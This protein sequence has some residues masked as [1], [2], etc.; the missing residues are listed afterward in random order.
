MTYRF[1]LA[2]S[3]WD[4]NELNAI[5][6]VIDSDR[7]TM[8]SHVKEFEKRFAE[9]IG[10]KYAVMVNSGSSAN[11]I[12]VASLFYTKDKE[13]QLKKGDEVIVPS[14]SWSTTYFPL[15]QYGLKIKFVDIDLETLNIDIE[16][17]NEAITERTKAIFCVN[18]LGNSSNYSAIKK[19][20]K[21]KNILILEDN[22]ESLGAEYEH[23]MNGSY[24]IVGTHSSFFSHH[25][26]TMEGGIAVTNDE[27]LY[28][29]M[30]S[31]RAHGWTRDLPDKNLISNKDQNNKFDEC[32]KFVLPGYNLRPLE[33]S[34]AI[35]IE[36]LKKLPDLIRA[37]R[38]NAN[39]FKEVMLNNENLL[40]QKEIGK[41]SWFGF[42]MII[43]PESNIT[44]KK[45]L[46]KLE[47]L[48]IETRPIVAGNFTNNLAIKYLD[49]EIHN[50]LTIS[51]Y[52][53]KNGLFIGNHHYP[54]DSMFEILKTIDKI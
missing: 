15:Y 40:I 14:I 32:F 53:D 27:E 31:I 46:Q 38:E 50:K 24:G 43:K 48:S 51:D 9:Y 33:M 54:L 47:E 41:S 5:Q 23:K 19:I 6:R 12:A 4:K 36:Q 21:D 10:T 44:R 16:Q 28:Q 1:P 37:R 7:F 13:K 2:S 18:L 8:G 11:L 20:V 25:I 45:L 17:L 49:Y 26:S 39:L 35:G 3:T 29:I 34:G 52:V 42:S 30:L 22:C